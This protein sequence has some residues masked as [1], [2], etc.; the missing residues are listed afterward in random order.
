MTLDDTSTTV[1]I[2][3]ARRCRGARRAA[4]SRR[5]DAAQRE[6]RG[7]EAA[8]EHQLGRQ[9]H[10]DADGERA[11][12]SG[13]G[14]SGT[15]RGDRRAQAAQGWRP[16]TQSHVGL[17]HTPRLRRDRSRSG[18]GRRVA[19]PPPAPTLWT[20]VRP[21]GARRRRA[22]ARGRRRRPPTSPGCAAWPGGGG[23]GRR[24]APSP[25]LSGAAVVVRR[26]PDRH[27]PLRH[28]AVQRP[29]RA[30]RAAR[31]GGAG[32]L[33]PRRADHARAA[34]G[35]SPPTKLHAAPRPRL[36]GRR[37]RHPSARGHRAVRLHAA[38]ALL[39]ARSTSGRCATASCT[40]GSTST[41]SWSGVLFAEAVVGLDLHRHRLEP[42]R[43]ASASC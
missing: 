6:V 23:A 24:P 36:A 38:V 12:P 4:A 28:H 21:G 2:E 5:V 42:S 10:D 14:R 8:E 22:R 29:R 34:G 32:A 16:T 31:H 15:A 1:K 11:G 18:Y 30:A 7:E 13:P 17:Y 43:P 9:P 39:H 19:S 27:R 25:F 26:H 37:R 35:A 3:R 41:S 20:L 33:R 40:R